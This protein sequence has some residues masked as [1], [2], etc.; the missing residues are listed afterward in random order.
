MRR[1]AATK[2]SKISAMANVKANLAKLKTAEKIQFARQIVTDMTSNP[3]FPT[4]TP[5]L[6]SV[7]AA[8]MALEEAYNAAQTARQLSKSRTAAVI[9][10][11]ESLNLALKQ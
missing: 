6:P 10:A 2:Q 5:A 7:V 8:A 3:N 11:H 1:A 9:P 4:P